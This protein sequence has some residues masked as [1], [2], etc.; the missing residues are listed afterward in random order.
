M[1]INKGDEGN[2][3]K[4]ANSEYELLLQI[5]LMKLI[6]FLQYFDLICLIP[7]LFYANRL[8]TILNVTVTSRR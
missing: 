3:I 1:N 7:L 8:I 2:D 5:R 6:E 4:I